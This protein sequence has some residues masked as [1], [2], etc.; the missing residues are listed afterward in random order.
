MCPAGRR[1][2]RALWAFLR[3]YL[4]RA[5]FSLPSSRQSG[6]DFL[7]CAGLSAD[8]FFQRRRTNRT[9]GMERGKNLRVIRIA[10]FCLVAAVEAVVFGMQT[11]ISSFVDS[12]SAHMRKHH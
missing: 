4:V 2:S 12:T 7:P 1:E 11:A 3:R 8:V 5:P 6:G 9:F 10:G